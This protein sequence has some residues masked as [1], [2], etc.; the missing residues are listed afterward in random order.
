[1]N[2]NMAGI[3][4]TVYLANSHGRHVV[5]RYTAIRHLDMSWKSITFF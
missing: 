3:S 4:L 2:S 5:K 1:M